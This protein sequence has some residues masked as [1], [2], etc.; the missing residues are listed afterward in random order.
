MK[1][2]P[3]DRCVHSIYSARGTVEATDLSEALSLPL[4]AHAWIGEGLPKQQAMTHPAHTVIWGP[5]GPALTHCRLWHV[6]VSMLKG[7]SLLKAMASHRHPRQY[8]LSLSCCLLV[9]I[10]KFSPKYRVTGERLLGR[11]WCRRG[12]AVQV[13][14]LLPSNYRTSRA[15]PSLA[16]EPHSLP[17][18]FRAHSVPLR[19]P[20]LHKAD[21]C[22]GP[23]QVNERDR[24]GECALHRRW[25]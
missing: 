11:E 9:N 21:R 22:P 3:L 10:L 17:V 6:G 15:M 1:F 5:P 18:S 19:S 8:W 13:V 4:G 25:S 24:E 16:G 20:P 7:L 2:H 14:Q 23:H 12:W